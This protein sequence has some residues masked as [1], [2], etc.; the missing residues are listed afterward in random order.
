[1]PGRGALFPPRQ[2]L[3]GAITSRGPSRESYTPS[4]KSGDWPEA[5]EAHNSPLWRLTNA[6]VTGEVRVSSHIS[7]APTA[8]QPSTRESAGDLGQNNWT[9]ESRPNRRNEKMP[10]AVP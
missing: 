5:P 2:K 9:T 8:N 10:R 4:Q 1:V 7:Q 6:A 3:L